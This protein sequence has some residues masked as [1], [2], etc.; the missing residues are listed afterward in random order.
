MG[1]FHHVPGPC[2]L[3]RSPVAGNPQGFSLSS[4]E[5]SGSLSLIHQPIPSRLLKS[6]TKST[7]PRWV[8]W[9]A[10]TLHFLRT[11][12]NPFS[13][14]NSPSRSDPDSYPQITSH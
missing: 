6:S 5:E 12:D 9:M 8:S 2:L 11:Q 13:V 7:K 10:Q 14:I 4:Q 1:A 3:A